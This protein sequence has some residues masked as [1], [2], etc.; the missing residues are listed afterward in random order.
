VNFYGTTETT[1]PKVYRRV[2][3]GGGHG[4]LPA[5]RCVPGT[6]V[7]L[8]EP[9][10][11][12]DADTVRAALARP[13]D[14]GEIVLVSRYCGHGYLGRADQTAERFVP[15]DDGTV[16]YRTGDLGRLDAGGELSVSGRADDELKINGV[17]IQPAEVETAIRG[18]LAVDDVAVTAA[19]G[20]AAPLT[21]H[22][23][24]AP[25]TVVTATGLRTRLTSVLP[26][27]MI[28]TRVLVHPALPALP[29]GK[30]DRAALS[31]RSTGG[32]TPAGGAPDDSG[33][34]PLPDVPP[35]GEIECWLAGQWAEWFDRP[36]VGAHD[37]LFA[38]GG[39]SIFAMRLAARIRA[40]FGVEI[41]V[42]TIFG[43]ASVRA[44]AAEIAAELSLWELLDQGADELLALLAEPPAGA[45]GPDGAAE[46]RDGTRAERRP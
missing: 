33:G 23:V 10:A 38:L 1:L 2:V 24:A 18:V 5:G 14:A 31:R 30:L 40:R 42:R 45:V 19:P 43:R 36:A 27:T 4:A 21:A 20:G 25:G 12:L 16:G 35:D 3:P 28:P 32:P 37:D 11:A 9:G 34:H 29:G 39:D 13:A 15:L 8:V 17:R 44:L 22:V 26:S 6:R 7:C 41:T 46:R